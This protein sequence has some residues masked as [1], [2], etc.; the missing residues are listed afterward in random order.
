[1]KERNILDQKSK[2]EKAFFVVVFIIFALHSFTLIFTVAWMLMSSFKASLE[3][4]AGDAFALPQKWL[5][6]NYVEAFK[7]L[8]N[9]K[10]TFFGMIFNS[11]WYTGICSVLGAFVPSVTG[12]VISKYDFK[13]K[14]LIF[15]VAIACMMIPI[16]G[17]TASYMKVIAYLGLYDT[18]MYVVITSL[19]GFGGTFLVYYGFWKSVS[20]SYAEAAE[21][22]GAGPF[23]IFF[24][25][26][27]PQGLPIML[28]YIVTGA[29]GN[30]NEYTTMILYLPSFPTLASGL[31]EYQSNAVRSIN[32]PVYFAGL[33]VSMI[34]T[35]VLFS[36]MS[37]KIMTSLS[38]GGLKG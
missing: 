4:S 9:G 16:V 38:I 14:K 3:Y 13:V 17:A 36:A 19:G 5:F 12:Y 33:I 2:G 15:T 32:Y 10:T 7:M 28:T 6:S 24:K 31:F 22:D 37:D 27:L 29:I 8:N 20:W 23:V 25:V 1:M 11:L 34:P 18:P 35:I 26:M 30:W 21:I